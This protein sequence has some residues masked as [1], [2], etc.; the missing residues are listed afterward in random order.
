MEVGL[1]TSYT[2]P[3]PAADIRAGVKLRYGTMYQLY[4]LEGNGNGGFN[5]SPTWFKEKITSLSPSV[6]S[7]SVYYLND[8]ECMYKLQVLDRNYRGVVYLDFC[9]GG[10]PAAFHTFRIK[11]QIVG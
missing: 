8:D 11:V 2:T 10:G 9:P 1:W 5:I 3:P 7:A 6:L 4:M